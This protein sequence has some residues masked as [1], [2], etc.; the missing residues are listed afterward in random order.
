LY[1]LN[2]SLYNDANENPAENRTRIETFLNNHRSFITILAL[3]TLLYVSLN[4]IYT[5]PG[6]DIYKKSGHFVIK[7]YKFGIYIEQGKSGKFYNFSPYDFYYENKNSNIKERLLYYS[8]EIYSKESQY[9]SK[10]FRTPY[11]VY[12]AM[13]SYFN[14]L[15]QQLPFIGK[16]TK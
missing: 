5:P 12:I 15:T 9:T 16:V 7:P 13:L 1:A 3:T 8:N 2:I 6:Q 14:K 11:Q 4:G 10:K